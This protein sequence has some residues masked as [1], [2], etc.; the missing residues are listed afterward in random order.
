MSLLWPDS[1]KW[2]CDGEIDYAEKPGRSM[3]EVGFYNHYGCSNSQTQAKRTIDVTQWHNYAVEWSPGGVVG[4]IDGAEWFRDASTSHLPPGPMHQT[5]QLDWFPVSGQ[6]TKASTAD[7]AW[8]RQYNLNG[9]STP[10]PNPPATPPPAPAPAPAAPAPTAP[11]PSAP[12]STS[13]TAYSFGAAGDMNGRGTY[14]TTG[15]SG[16]NS[17]SIASQLSSGAISN[18]FGLGDFQYDTAYCADY[19]KYWNVAGWSKVKPKT[20]WISA[21]NRRLAARAERGP[22]RLHERRVRR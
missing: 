3:T 10:T 19:T 17:A 21:P 15:P 20:Y 7:F 11:A 8:V 16:K 4:Y 9:G 13:T 6:S 5:L 1:G 12:N 22:G 18:F 14:S 2:P